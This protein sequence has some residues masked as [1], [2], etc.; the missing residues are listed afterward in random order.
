VSAPAR[1]ASTGIIELDQVLGGLY[2]GDNVVLSVEEPGDSE[3]FYAAA[4]DR[5]GEYDA[6]G[7]VTLDRDLDD[8]HERF[9]GFDVI[10]GRLG[11]DFA[12][13]G[14]LLDE[15]AKWSARPGAR[16]LL[17]D[18]LDAM[19]A[20]WGDELAGRFFSRGCPL[21]LG[22]GSIAYWSL[23]ASR[24]SA[25]VRREIEAVTQ[26]VLSVGDGRLRVVKA[27]GRAVGV[28]GSVYRYELERGRPVL[29]S[30]PAAARLGAA[31]KELRRSRRLS[32]GELADL[33]GVS[34]SAISQ[35]ERGRRGL[36]LDTLLALTGRL[37]MTLDELLRG[38][39]E[40]PGYRLVR[41]DDPRHAERDSP[42]PLLDDPSAGLRAYVVRLSPGAT[43]T[44]AFA[45]K[46]VE[47]VAVASGLVQ[48]RL[49]TGTPV[50]RT[51]EALIADRSGVAS[52][53]NLTDR[54][55]LVFW[56]LH[57]ES[58][59]VT[60][61]E[62]QPLPPTEVSAEAGPREESRRR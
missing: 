29:E 12:Q 23:T 55:A 13:P 46:G 15:I 27:E 51:G 39:Q 48:V 18:S 14:Q 57:D 21:L 37:N 41:R 44:P 33:A 7:F 2:W 9:P 45:H 38:G 53:R 16:L 5:I 6:A 3:P 34:P 49:A 32:Q 26:C 56:V 43:A 28:Q 47:L 52:W 8:I 60:L 20:H 54:E 25:S 11:A 22:L 10:D 1:T 36:S 59:E 61:S 58:P 31:L 50:L 24:H 19:S 42:V 17:F 4:A 40:A 30:A 35:A 62:R